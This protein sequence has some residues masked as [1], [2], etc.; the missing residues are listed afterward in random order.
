VWVDHTEITPD[1]HPLVSVPIIYFPPWLISAPDGQVLA[2]Y[3]EAFPDASPCES[4]H[5]RGRGRDEWVPD[6]GRHI[7]GW[8]EL[9]MNWA[10]PGGPGGHHE[11][12][13]YVEAMTRLYNG[14]R[15]LFP[16]A[17]KTG[18]SMHP[19]MAWWA[20]LHTLSMLAR[21]QPAEWAAHINIDQSRN[22]VAVERVLKLAISLVPALIAEAIDQ[23]ASTS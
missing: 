7:D 23:V 11:K 20:V 13:T 3:L 9:D 12:I 14:K 19:L 21:Y 1:P 16:A 2:S 22:A 17:G 8:G 18:R 6:F 10:L 15:W 5:R 4:Y